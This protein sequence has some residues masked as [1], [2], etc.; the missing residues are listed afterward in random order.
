MVGAGYFGLS[1]ALITAKRPSFSDFK[2]VLLDVSHLPTRNAASLDLNRIVRSDYSNPLYASLAAEAHKIWRISDWGADGRY[3]EASLLMLGDGRT[4]Y[5]ENDFK[6]AITLARTCHDEA[7][8]LEVESE[9]E[10]ANAC[11]TGGSS[12][13]WGYLNR[14]SGWVDPIAALIYTRELVE[15]ASRVEIVTGK[16][17]RLL[18][19]E[20]KAIV[21]GVVLEN[22]SSILAS[23]TVLA[24]GAWTPTLLDLRDRAAA[25]AEVFAYIDLNSE[26]S[27][28]LQ[29]M[30]SII[31]L[32]K[33]WFIMP[34]RGGVLKVARHGE[35][36][37]DKT[38]YLHPQAGEIDGSSPY[39][40][41]PEKEIEILDEGVQFCR[42]AMEEL[43]TW[44][45]D[46]KFDRVRLCWY[47]DT[48]TADFIIDFH[49]NV[50]GL[51]VA[52][53]GSGHAFKFLPVLGERIIDAMEGKLDQAYRNLWCWKLKADRGH[54]SVDSE[55]DLH[56]GAYCARGGIP[57]T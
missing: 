43:I 12:G 22:G 41:I 57:A 56:N 53:G 2:I 6:L 44:L 32:S 38:K 50:A 55:E 33:G 4:E 20:N 29:G 40:E 51:F 11:N 24:T 49:P 9:V 26:E 48:P 7:A 14:R 1:T 46:R 54:A 8:V 52:T 5:L 23:L 21:E 3:T 30:L 37:S 36:F 13:K 47:T 39:T 31:N 42:Q 15:E 45:R 34:P 10:I 35:G 28:H 16:V 27:A 18:L 19:S 25:S 17:A